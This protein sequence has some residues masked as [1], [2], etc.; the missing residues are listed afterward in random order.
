MGTIKATGFQLEVV[1]T[2]GM[3]LW[4]RLDPKLLGKCQLV[5]QAMATSTSTNKS[6]MLNLL[7]T[8]TSPWTLETS[9][10]EAGSVWRM[11]M[12]RRN[13]TLKHLVRERPSR[14]QE[15]WRPKDT[16]ERIRWQRTSR[17][18]KSPNQQQRHLTKAATSNR[19]RSTTFSS[20][21]SRMAARVIQLVLLDWRLPNPRHF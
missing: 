14:C 7:I 17:T 8:T 9:I 20:S 16:A 12:G 1:S 5:F 11:K 13:L 18:I 19:P 15:Y 21:S 4:V 6:I 3:D 2:K 10:T